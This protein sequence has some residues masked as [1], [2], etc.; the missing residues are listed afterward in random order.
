[1]QR[2]KQDYALTIP[3]EVIQMK[4]KEGLLPANAGDGS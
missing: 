4:V 3:N 2:L 1:M